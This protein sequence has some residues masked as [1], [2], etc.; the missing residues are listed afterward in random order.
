L[1]RC[2][3]ANLAAEQR[4]D[5]R[6]GH[7]AQA[8]LERLRHQRRET[9]RGERNTEPDDTDDRDRRRDRP[10]YN[11]RDAAAVGE[12][13]V[14]PAA[15]GDQ[16]RRTSGIANLESRQRGCGQAGQAERTGWTVGAADVGV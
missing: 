3:V 2:I 7:G 1:A 9:V 12:I 6:V 14:Q 4:P 13:F 5:L 16:F 15:A 10:A 11:S 8:A